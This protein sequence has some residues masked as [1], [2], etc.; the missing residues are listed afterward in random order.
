[1]LVVGRP[2]M[3]F[4]EVIQEYE[5]RAAR[6]W[7]LQVVEVPS[8][9][10]A[11]GQSR[12]DR[13]IQVEETKLLKKIPNGTEVVALTRLGKAMGSVELARYLERKALNSTSEVSFVIGGAL[14]L[15]PGVMERADR[16]FNLSSLTLNHQLARLL[17]TEQL[18]RAGTILRNEPYH[19][20]GS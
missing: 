17:L 10:G 15:G 4:R 8:G 16:T 11:K 18:Y 3:L 9:T 13:V 14:G 19:K 2:G 7:K 5:R 12:P 20:G 1:M 6:Y